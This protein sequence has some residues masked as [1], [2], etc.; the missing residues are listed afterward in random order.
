LNL[1]RVRVGVEHALKCVQRAVSAFWPHGRD[2]HV[3][4]RVMAAVSA[5][6]P[7]VRPAA[8]CTAA[9]L[10][11]CPWMSRSAPRRATSPRPALSSLRLC[12]HRG[13]QSTP[14]APMP[15]QA[16][17]RAG[18]AEVAAAAWHVVLLRHCPVDPIT[19][20]GVATLPR[21]FPLLP[22]LGH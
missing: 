11:L 16:P 2:H 13:A 17:S 5:L 14:P 12:A 18:R 6:P 15:S 9:S 20:A 8:A 7:C 21:W 4:G 22:R 19:V 10:R 1:N 3:A